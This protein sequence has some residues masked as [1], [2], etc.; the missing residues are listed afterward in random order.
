MKI[1]VLTSI[2][3]GEG[4]PKGFTPVVHYFTKEWVKLGYEVCVMHCCTYFPSIYYK[5]PKWFRKIIQNRIGFALPE[6]RFDKEVEYEYE[7]VKVHRIP[8]KKILPMGNYPNLELKKAC[9]RAE[10]YLKKEGFVPDHI[11]S[12]WLN[13]QLV[14]M[15]YLKA[16]TGAVTTMVLH[17]VSSKEKRLFKDWDRLVE[18]VDNWG[19]RSL[20]IKE[21]FE[22]I[23]IRPTCS[24]RCFSG[25]PEYYTQNIPYRDGS[26][27]H[28]YVQVGMLMK[29]KFPDKTIEAI[30]SV[31]GDDNYTLRLVGNGAMRER[32]ES[33]VSRLGAT[34]R[35]CL[36]GRLPRKEIIPILD[37]SDV[38]ILISRGEV[39]GLVYIEAM[40]R[41][42]IVIA[43]RGEG[44]EGIIIHGENGFL[45]E[46]GNAQDLAN[47]IQ[48]I[49]N[50]TNE[51]RDK[52]SKAAMATSLKLTDV[53][54]AK[55]YIDTVIKYGK[56]RAY[57]QQECM[58]KYHSM[59]LKTPN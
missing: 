3:P 23:Y 41:G 56:E 37:Q 35:I 28:R 43:S 44:M 42:C 26:F 20:K 7:G 1:L 15:S 14:L 2:Y 34:K 55:D 46:A 59:L 19:Y 25:I 13:P 49:K 50:L 10:R 31:Y 58:Y 8:M 21:E 54:V 57:N 40:A 11:I 30:A 39:F 6:T 45:C 51:E 24:F 9:R 27:R 48:Q 38:F 12:H 16:Q 17:G 5:A 22:Q 18:N 29:R 33:K 47:V 53:A 36:L 52:I 4:I 32:L